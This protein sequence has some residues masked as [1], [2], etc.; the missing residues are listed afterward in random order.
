MIPASGRVSPARLDGRGAAPGDGLIWDGARWVP[1]PGGDS[2]HVGTGPDSTAVGLGAGAGEESVA[3]GNGADADEGVV[4]YAVAV[5]KDAYADEVGTAVGYQAGA[6][7]YGVAVGGNAAAYG[8]ESTSLG[9]AATNS[10]A[11]G[12]AIGY[13]ATNTVADLALVKANDLELERSSAGTGTSII[14]ADTSTGTRYRLQVT[15]GALSITLA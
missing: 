14:L 6:D 15:G 12:I 1:G 4:G 5:G 7:S 13:D 9:T 3:V 8:A 11:R 2:D 10:G